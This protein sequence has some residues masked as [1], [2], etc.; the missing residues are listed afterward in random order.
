MNPTDS[1]Q[2]EDVISAWTRLQGQIWDSLFGI[3]R[4][5]VGQ[6]WEQFYSRPL[7]L[8]EDMVNCLLQQQSD[9]IRIAIK[10]VKPGN[11]APKVFA[12]WS[13]QIEKAAQHWVDAQRQA[14]KTWFAAVKQM[15]PC[16]AQ[17]VSRGK[18]E[19]YPDNVFE[20]WQQ[21]TL[22]TLQVQADWLSSLVSKGGAKTG[23]KITRAAKAATDNGVQA[24]REGSQTA[25]KATSSTAPKGGE[26]RRGAA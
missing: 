8:G 9:S 10:A 11:G 3:G 21:V 23:E 16:C 19:H 17:G 20:A 12:D 13:E 15:D 26:A 6:P 24:T 2:V 18:E 1:T 25:R 22:Q 4:G 5:D 7:E 14:W